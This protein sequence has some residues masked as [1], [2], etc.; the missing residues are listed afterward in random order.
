MLITWVPAK[1]IFLMAAAVDLMFGP[2][3]HIWLHHSF[4]I[5]KL[6]TVELGRLVAVCPP[7]PLPLPV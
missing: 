6:V 3:I 7:L 5:K 1:Y 2:E 4:Q